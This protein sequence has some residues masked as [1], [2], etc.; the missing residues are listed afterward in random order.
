[1]EEKCK[2]GGRTEEI[3]GEVE[4]KYKSYLTKAWLAKHITEIKSQ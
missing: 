2:S 1:M 4:E 3:G